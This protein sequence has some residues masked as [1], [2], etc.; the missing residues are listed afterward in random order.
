MRIVAGKFRSRRLRPVGK[1]QLRPTS[2]M[3]RETLFN[4]LGS[5]VEGSV[6]VDYFAGTGAV[7]IEALS[8]GA[9]RAI[10][11]EKHVAT[12]THI[13]EN[14]AA[15]GIIAAAYRGADSSEA[16][17]LNMDGQ[18][19][20]AQLAD[21]PEKINFLF[22]DPP[23]AD[24]RICFETLEQFIQRVALALGA[25]VIIEHPS[26]KDLPPMIGSF[27][28]TRILEQGD[29]ALSFYRLPVK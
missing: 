17:I 27:A 6:F 25:V 12:A 8:R 11:I 4:I 22:A 26:K 2:D 28:R 5:D 16:E 19:G 13:R 14:L 10:F 29:S 15:L 24:V 20:L 3:L 21:R 9:K 23:Y 7:G 18:R 1:L